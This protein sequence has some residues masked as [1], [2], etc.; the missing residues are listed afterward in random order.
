MDKFAELAEGYFKCSVNTVDMIETVG[1][2]AAKFIQPS[3][4]VLLVSGT[5]DVA[6]VTR[7]SQLNS[8]LDMVERLCL[9]KALFHGDA[10]GVDKWCAGYFSKIIDRDL[11]FPFP[12][13]WQFHG[14]SAGP[15]R[16]KEMMDFAIMYAETMDLP[17]RYLAFPAPE[18]KGTRH[19]I[20]IMNKEKIIGQV[21]ELG[22]HSLEEVSEKEKEKV[23]GDKQGLLELWDSVKCL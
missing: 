3:G 20:S 15:I 8:I 9:I 12:A 22:G 2:E 10:P 18:S 6:S 23:K 11:I 16:N 1:L 5:R 21:V 17:L 13:N 19:M 7:Y 14:K 4:I